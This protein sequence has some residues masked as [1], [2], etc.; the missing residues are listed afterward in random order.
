[1][2]VRLPG[3]SVVCWSGDRGTAGTAADDHSVTSHTR[4]NGITYFMASLL[5][6]NDAILFKENLGPDLADFLCIELPFISS[7]ISIPVVFDISEFHCRTF[8][9]GSVVLYLKCPPTPVDTHDMFSQ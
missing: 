7:Y 2:A 5:C 4:V 1:M 6:H 8:L 9:N 3:L